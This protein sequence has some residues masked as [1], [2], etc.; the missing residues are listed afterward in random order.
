ML[1]TLQWQW[2]FVLKE[3][4]SGSKMHGN[5]CWL[6]TIHEHRFCCEMLTSRR[7]FE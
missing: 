2:T 6:V 3:Q 7:A 1:A 4:A 5:Y